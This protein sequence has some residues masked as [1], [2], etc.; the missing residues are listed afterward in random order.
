[1]SAEKPDKGK[2]ASEGSYQFGIGLLE[3]RA[4]T[5]IIDELD[6]G[7]ELFDILK[8]PYIKNRIDPPKLR[9]LLADPELLEAFRDEI[10]KARAGL[11]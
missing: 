5:Y 1:M 10:D 4:I 11:K 6:G 9:Q 2:A 8:D 7:R 3:R